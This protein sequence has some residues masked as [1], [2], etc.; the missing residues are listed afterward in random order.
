LRERVLLA[1]GFV[2]WC[3]LALLRRE[4]RRLPRYDRAAA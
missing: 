4:F 3:V 2:D 1:S